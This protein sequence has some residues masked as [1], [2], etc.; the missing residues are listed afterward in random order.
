MGSRLFTA[1]L[2]GVDIWMGDHLDKIPCAV[3]VGKS[4][5]R[6]GRQLRFPL[7]LQVLYVD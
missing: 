7:L 5:W 1:L 4:G 6:S 2:D 3:L